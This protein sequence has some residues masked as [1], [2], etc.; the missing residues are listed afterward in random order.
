MG[1]NVAYEALDTDH[2][3]S[4]TRLQM[5]EKTVKFLAEQA[6]KTEECL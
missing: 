4:D 6:Q 5:I 1:G 3:F 2:S